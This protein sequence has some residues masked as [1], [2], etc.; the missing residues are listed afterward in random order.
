[1]RHTTITMGLLFGMAS[2]A[3][4]Q[5]RPSGANEPICVVDGSYRPPNECGFQPL[6]RPQGPQQA[7]DP[8][9]RYL[10]PPE[11]VMANQQAIRL[12]DRQRASIQEAMRDAQMKFVDLQF[13][14]TGECSLTSSSS[15]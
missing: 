14:M 15:S 11:L 5:G 4:G 12:T 6:G 1:M 13:A 8:L 7:Q 2:L 10:F 9:A 3:Q